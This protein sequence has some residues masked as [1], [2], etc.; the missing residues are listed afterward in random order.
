MTSLIGYTSYVKPEDKLP[1]QRSDGTQG[2]V[3]A[4]IFVD[5][6]TEFNK[7]IDIFEKVEVPIGHILGLRN[8]SAFVGEVYNIACRKVSDGYLE[9][10]PHQDGYPDLLVLDEMGSK[11]WQELESQR[12]EKEPFSP[13]KTGGIEVKATCGD[14]R[15]AKWF[16]AKGLQKPHIGEKRTDYITG[17]NWKAHHRE[18]NN[19]VGLIWDFVEGRPTIIA[20]MYSHQLNEMDW[21]KTVVPKEGGGRTTSVS[22]MNSGGMNKMYSGILAVTQNEAYSVKMMDRLNRY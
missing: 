8:L 13:Y 9:N 10:N 2:L 17:Y 3:P 20:I 18:T 12:R 6:L 16:T 21:G 19:L 14:C 1:F 7:T 5:A 4:R 22:I 11:L 15:T